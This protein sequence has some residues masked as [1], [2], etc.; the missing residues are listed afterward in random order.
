MVKAK[1]ISKSFAVLGTTINPYLFFWQA[2]QEV[3]EVKSTPGDRPLKKDPGQASE[4]LNRIRWDTYIGMAVSNGVGYFIMLTAAVSLHAQGQTNVETA[5]QAAQA[6][7]PV[8][9]HFAFLLFAAGIIGTGLLAV[10][11][12]AGS[13]AYA[14]GEALK[15]SVGLERKPLEAKGFYGVLAV[16]TLLGLSMNFFHIDPIKAL[17]WAAVLSGITAVPIMIMMMVMASDPK[18][19]GKFTLSLPLKIV[20]WITTFIMLTATIGLLVTWGK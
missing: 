7:K 17:V 18:V 11:V 2:S 8:A 12:L 10:P 3:E 15:W 19:M 4:Q 5:A 13:A 9:G 16:A 20:G 1:A 14:V 6:L